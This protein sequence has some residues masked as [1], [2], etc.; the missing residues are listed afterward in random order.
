MIGAATFIFIGLVGFWATLTSRLAVWRFGPVWQLSVFEAIRSFGNQWPSAAMM[1][2]NMKVRLP[3]R[4]RRAA[5]IA[6]VA[7]ICRG[8]STS[9]HTRAPRTTHTPALNLGS[10]R[11]RPRACVYACVRICVRTA[12]QLHI[13]PN[14]RT[15]ALVRAWSASAPSA[16]SASFL[17]SDCTF[18]VRVIRPV[19]RHTHFG[20]RP[21]VAPRRTLQHSR[22]FLCG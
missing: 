9:V 13:P 2:T 20:T 12:A 10:E 7:R 5:C 19:E 14:L 1:P 11:T 3:A 22:R 16:L 15:A 6:M 18:S 4:T 17:F 21:T 8:V